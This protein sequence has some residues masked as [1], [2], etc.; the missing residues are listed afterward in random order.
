MYIAAIWFNKKAILPNANQAQPHT[1]KG[2]VLK[3]ANK[4]FS[5]HFRVSC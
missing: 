3:Q 5:E 4:L 2:S 1:I